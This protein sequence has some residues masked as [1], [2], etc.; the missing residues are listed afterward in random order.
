MAV[1]NVF[2][3]PPTDDDFEAMYHQLLRQVYGAD[4]M[5]VGRNG[6]SQSGVDI[7][8]HDGTRPVGVQCKHYAKKK[9]TLGTVEDD[10][11]KAEKA[12]IGIEHLIFA[13]TAP[14]DA[15]V[16]QKVF[17]LSNERRRAGKFTVTVEFW[18]EICAQI[19][20]HPAVGR[21]Y[22]PGF[23]G[24]TILEV[25]DIVVDTQSDVKSILGGQHELTRNVI[26]IMQ[27]IGTGR[28]DEADPRV[29]AV[30]NTI[31]DKIRCGKLID[32]SELLEN[33]GNPDTFRDKFS[34]YR[35][36][37][38][39]AAVDLLSGRH[40][41]AAE[42]LLIA[43]D[44]APEEENAH[45][46]KVRALYLLNR[47]EDA[48][49]ACDTALNKFQHSA[50]LWAMYVIIQTNQGHPNP[51]LSV[52]NEVA[53]SNE[54]LMA[55]SEFLNKHNR[56]QDAI[57]LVKRVMERGDHTFDTRRTYLAE[58]LAWATMN[59][60][61][62]FHK[63]ISELQRKEL[64][65]AVSK[66]E[67]IEAYFATLQSDEARLEVANNLSVALRLLGHDER[68]TKIAEDTLASN[69]LADTL[70]RTYIRHL[71]EDGEF[72][73][74]KTITE[75]LMD[76]LP[77]PVLGMLSETSAR[78]GDIE[79]CQRSIN[80]ARLNFP[81]DERLSELE[82][83]E[84][85][86]YRVAGQPIIALEGIRKH[87]EAN[88]TQVTSLIIYAQFLKNLNQQEE[89]LAQTARL[90]RGMKSSSSLT[91][92]IQVA[93]LLFSMGQ[94]YDAAEL[95][96]EVLPSPGNDD[97]TR[98]LLISLDKTDQRV[99]A[100]SLIER[101]D[102]SAREL[103]WVVR[104]ECNLALR[105]ADWE[106]LRD[107][108]YE[109]LAQGNQ[110]AEFVLAYISALYHLQEFQ[111]LDNYLSLHS[112]F[113]LDDVDDNF[114]YAK[115]E[116]ERGYKE[117]GILRL[118][119]VYRDNT[120]D[121]KAAGNFLGTLLLHNFETDAV[122]IH[123][124]IPGT[125]IEFSSA[126][127][128]W[129]LALDYSG[130]LSQK[131][132]P[133]LVASNSELSCS[134]L[135]LRV[136]DVITYPRNLRN[137]QAKVES[138]SSL[139][140]FAARKAK[141]LIQASAS[142]QGPIWSLTVAT[143][144]NGAGLAQILN[145]EGRHKD[146]RSATLRDYAKVHY[147]I[148]MLASLLGTD[149]PQLV[150]GWSS[151]DVLLF[152]ARGNKDEAESASVLLSTVI[153]GAV[154]DLLS[155]IEITRHGLWE[156]I[157]HRFGNLMVATST[158]SALILIHQK[159]RFHDIQPLNEVDNI[160][161]FVNHGELVAS[162]IEF[163]NKYCHVSPAKGPEV[164][165]AKLIGLSKILDALT[166]DTIYLALE[167]RALLLAEDAALREI[168]SELGHRKSVGLQPLISSFLENG[169]ITR[170]TYVRIII[171]KIKGGQGFVGISAQDLAFL[172][173]SEPNK[174][175]SDVNVLLE[176]FKS[177]YLV[178]DKA[179]DISADFISLIIRQLPPSV[180]ASYCKSIYDVLAYGRPIIAY[181]VRTR[182][183]K[184]LQEHYGRAGRK[185]NKHVRDY[186]GT[187][188]K[189]N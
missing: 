155:I 148:S 46:N 158:R 32:A 135:G 187:F 161:G 21:A 42:R 10:V 172:A 78:C 39:K 54:V 102:R 59:S 37:S 79:W 74:I 77:L 14:N 60:A 189:R 160:S 153:S 170:A 145:I 84:W 126:L 2:S 121:S 115:Y 103:D 120:Q 61:L 177:P 108:A 92:K 16:V 156:P 95:F 129:V 65:D 128:N 150:M 180:V 140:N 72:A 63:H 127:E 151:Y 29:A 83:L 154:L 35:W 7:L 97:L 15:T 90:R 34:Q 62:A 175:S 55:Q 104:T 82:I 40:K 174:A 31:R 144:D 159:M 93:E 164:M 182:L 38:N 12:G 123:E 114:E 11:L 20:M 36:H 56:H 134:L 76:K 146:A 176:T 112:G 117:S 131:S 181:D 17:E 133:E 85:E 1:T 9:F 66:F 26:Q 122:E 94:Y 3:F 130:E 22:I 13:T 186:F 163:I 91:D 44:Y 173:K 139:L 80:Q 98:Q 118:Y 167:H 149:L 27:L 73:K 47:V 81:S 67:P 19:R 152:V 28:G 52:P 51:L 24:G 8:G 178:M 179:L 48:L 41:Q 132:W 166:L 33:L 111:T 107:R 25:K 162:S 136:G 53:D 165:P 30:L 101:M 50:A 57:A 100:L 157:I 183:S 4:W 169:G 113:L 109:R 142:P 43:F 184:I 58:A 71:A 106:R 86:A 18:S 138:I 6:Q 23:P 88:P 70:L 171:S 125:V 105:M 185:L 188:L 68:A 89:A 75:P 116:I 45:C 99:K 137:I 143:N 168:S 124:V 141:A 87:V 96:W 110:S 147:P 49:L 5:R 69:P 64:E 119:R